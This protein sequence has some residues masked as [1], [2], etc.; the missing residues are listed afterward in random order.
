MAQQHPLLP[1]RTTRTHLLRLLPVVAALCLTGWMAA[2]STDPAYA[3]SGESE[4]TC[5]GGGYNPTPTAVEIQ[6]VPIVVESTTSDYFV[7]YV[8]H[9]VD[10]DTSIEI[11]VLIEK[12]AADTTTLAENVEALPKERYRVEKYQIANPADIDGDCID[13][14]TELQN[15][16][17]KNPLNP[18]AAIALSDG[19]VA[20]PDQDTFETL[21]VSGRYVKFAV[22]GADTD[23]PHIY[24]INTKTYTYHGGFQQALTALGIEESKA[25]DRFNGL[26]TFHPELQSADGSPGLYSIWIYRAE[27]FAVNNLIY[28]LFAANMS[29]LED[30]FA[31]HLREQLQLA[32]RDTP[33]YEES[34]MHLLLDG[35][36]APEGDFVPINKAE[37]YGLLRSMDLED[38]PNP[39]DVVIYE[40]LPNELPRVAGIITTVA[41]TPLSHVSLRAVQDGV[42]NA[43]IRGAL[44]KPDINA[45]TGH[46]VQYTVTADGYTIRAATKAEIDNHYASSRPAT[47][48][49]PQRDLSVT[50][51]TPLRW[52]GFDD[53]DAFG[54]K[55][56]N[57]AV[58]RALDFP[59][60]T[61][62]DGF[63]IP[64]YFYD[65]FMKHNGF[66]DD[67]REMLADPD[68][69]SDFDTQES[70][71]KKL[72]KAIKKA[73]TPQWIIDAIV[74]MNQGF[75]EGINRR[76]RS[77]TNNEDLP[78]FS[79]AGL[80]DSKSQKPSEDEEDLAKSLKEVYASLWNFRAF[81]E[82]DFH[83]IDHLAAA[84]GILVHP[85]YQ[86]EKVNGVAVSFDLIAGRF[87]YYYVNSQIGEDLVT[88][89][90]ALS[91]PEEVL[92]DIYGGAILLG[93]SNQ[94]APGQRLMSDDQLLLLRDHLFVIHHRFKRLYQ[95]AA[96]DPFAMEIEFKITSENKLAIKQARPWVFRSESQAGDTSEPSPT[97]T[98]SGTAQVGQ[99]LTADTSGI[100]DEDGLTNVSY[101]YQWVRNDGNADTDI[102]G[103]TA[104]THELSDSDEGK[105][106]RVRVSFT[107]DADNEESRTSA[108][109]A[110]VAPRPALT[111]T[112]PSSPYQSARHKGAEDRPQAIVA[113]SLPVKSFTKA[114]PS[115]LL[116]SATVSSMR[117]HQEDGLENAWIFFLDPDGNEDIG[118][119]LVAG[120]PCDG[121]GICTEDGD[122]LSQGAVKTL[123]G[124]QEDEPQPDDQ[125]QNNPATGAPAIDGTPQV[126]ETLTASTSDI[127]DQDGLTSATFEYQWI[128]GGSDIS[129][130]TSSTYTLTASEQ[131]QTIQVKVSFT[132]DRN[133]A[134]TLTSAATV[135]VAAAA[136]LTATFQALPDSHDGSA[137]FTFQVLFSEDVGISYVNMRDDAFTV[138]EGDVTGAR[139]VD[140]RN[141]LWEV[142]VE[143]D[144]DDGV[145]V[146]L[147]G[148][149]ACTTAGAVCTREDS[150]RQLTNSPTATVTGPAEEP[151]T[152]TSAAGAPTISGTPQVD[153]TLTADTSAI[154]DE[155]GL[156]NV[157]YSYQWLAGGSDI[158]GATRS[159]Y[160][161]T[162]SE[163][164]GAIQVKVSFTDDE[165]N[166]ETLT[167][168]ATV[169]VA[170]AP[171]RDATGAPTIGGTPQVDQTLTAD[172]ANIADQDGLSGVSYT[173]Q[174]IAGGSDIDGATGS[175]YTLTA[176]E[177]GQTIQVKVSFTDDRNNPETLTSVATEVVSRS[178]K[179]VVDEATPVWSAD[180]LVVE[181][182]SVSIGAA[183][184]DLFSNV[185]GSASLHIKSLWSYT[186]NRDLRLAF[187]EGVPGA[188][189]L[190]LQV[191]DL[192]LP[193]PAGSSGQSS[194]KWTDVDVDWE[195]G[196][197]ISARIVPTSA[198]VTPQPN[199][200]ATGAPTI[201]GAAQVDETLTADVSSIAD[202]DGLTNV[203][204]S[205]Q[206]IRNDGNS[207][208]DIGGATSPTYTPSDADVGKTIEVRVTFT[209]DADNE[210][211][212]TS[213]ATEVVQQGSNAWSATMTVG[214]RDGFTG[215]SFWGNP[216]L[217]SLSATEV[218]WDGKTHYVRFLFLKDGELRLGLN[219][220]M[221]STGFVL[222]VG[223]EEF[224]SAK[225]IVDH[226]GAS[227][228]FRWDDPGLGWSDGE[229]VSVNL[230]QSDQN[231]PALGPPTIS[232]TVQVDE[233][234]TA[235]TSGVE[236]A[237][238]LTNVSYRYQ[239]IAGGS[240]ID[241][242]TGASYTLTADEEGL[243]IQVWVSFED[244]AGHPETL[245]SAATL[246]VAPKPIPLTATFSN[247][248]TSHDGSTEFTFE[249]TFS[250]NFPLS[251][252]TLRDHAFTEDDNGPITKAQRKVQGS[253][254]TWTI[255][256][257]PKGNGTITI[258]LPATTDCTATGAICTDDGR[259]LSNATTVTVA[260]PE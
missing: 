189:D 140:G 42:P 257:D 70:E 11:P 110:T 52:I 68:F 251:Y 180:M 86:D 151:P 210:E 201:T 222:S 90:E 136:P 108:A 88:N 6:A 38:S 224:G 91:V 156:E 245:T 57:V 141:D 54:V 254:Q 62:P 200:P 242:A 112:F 60:G 115:V 213:A 137:T 174:W 26:L 51:I 153:Q 212:L 81:V 117:Q 66:Y 145:A 171:N 130:A 190:T 147:T 188:A 22:F 63:A 16:G 229:E 146:T 162:A 74:E 260:G 139:R 39:R 150:P 45:L 35:D 46:Y 122:A 230:I 65:E 3:Q 118:F 198:T 186:L 10:E 14:M 61:V 246:A 47:A 28:T 1:A 87:D 223:D 163:Q 64:F 158:S 89:P 94:V 96:D 215:Y 231:T 131:G 256:V 73:E 259:K 172:T 9:D 72:R 184:A 249:L 23:R 202:S 219:E 71:L 161:L 56:A 2:F 168:E 185:G 238:G 109:T 143:P 154:T 182:T 77:S 104:S 148:N 252:A 240:D 205:Y 152:N 44:D 142:T 105:T 19:A 159:S 196:Q 211:T 32:Y 107:D 233:T 176:S 133:N 103:A 208:T 119:S 226:A 253:N 69:Q 197:T 235:D 50:E 128:A 206:W 37:G 164:G 127:A 102:K 79:G 43:F 98:I 250:E 5:P 155:D 25:G 241:G 76:Y 193:F 129:G 7:L 135:E 144:G 84:M 166:E 100:T 78:G 33:L 75:P 15:L 116:T 83:R 239:W 178:D 220:E 95:P 244:D 58:L 227:Y 243:A 17:K 126:G 160:T 92:L 24:F 183:S 173:Y 121:G 41:Q 203:S 149:R 120:Q 170:A 157:S 225:A 125:Q 258:T 111:A 18:A 124:P 36:V 67:I 101:S 31:F 209:D 55:A 20:I 195:D 106:V 234:L 247:M 114:T 167:S 138:D 194:F 177:Q 97:V 21:A 85:S 132:D 221:F 216:H 217:G 82:R 123:P 187:E 191:G 228:R 59:E 255:T 4:E 134:E 30:D 49:T 34:R 27:P 13:D 248:P 169:A 179:P 199:T 29:L 204:Y 232:G 8:Q 207:D 12:G 237:D 80:Y 113:F 99:T 175:S 48:Q 181:Y 165:G 236:D 40:A 93:A 192:K 53:W 218:E 214:T